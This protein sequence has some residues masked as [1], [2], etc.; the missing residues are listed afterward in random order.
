M[1]FTYRFAN[2]NVKSARERN[3]GLQQ[4]DKSASGDNKIMVSLSSRLVRPLFPKGLF[5]VNSMVIA[6]F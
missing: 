4:D 1:A 6:A 5:F 3:T 2:K